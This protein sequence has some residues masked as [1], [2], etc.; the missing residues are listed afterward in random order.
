MFYTLAVQFQNHTSTTYEFNG[1]IS[2]TVISLVPFDQPF[3]V[4]V[5]TR[6]SDPQSAEGLLKV[7]VCI[8]IMYLT[9]YVR[10]YVAVHVYI[11]WFTI[12]LMQHIPS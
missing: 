6:E 4:Q 9:I 3:S 1:L 2:F 8:I 11:C 5:C 12:G 10:T 7:C